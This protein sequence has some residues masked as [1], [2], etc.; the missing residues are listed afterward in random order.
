MTPRQKP[1]IA[2]KSEAVLDLLLALCL[3]SFLRNP[4]CFNHECTIQKNGYSVKKA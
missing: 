3:V 1:E 2:R 4:I